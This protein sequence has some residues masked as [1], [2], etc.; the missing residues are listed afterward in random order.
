MILTF[1]SSENFFLKIHQPQ[2]GNYQQTPTKLASVNSSQ[3]SVQICIVSLVNSRIRDYDA[4]VFL[5]MFF[6]IVHTLEL[7]NTWWWNTITHFF[8]LHMRTEISGLSEHDLLNDSTRLPTIHLDNSF[9]LVRAC[10]AHYNRTLLYHT[11]YHTQDACFPFLPCKMKQFL[12]YYRY[13]YICV[14]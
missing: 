11:G 9:H 4:I 1:L 14:Y 8:D 12:D 13:V 10:A 2:Y 7:R 5:L 3:N 6:A